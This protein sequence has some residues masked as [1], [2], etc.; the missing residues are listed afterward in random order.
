M[1]FQ[2][3]I[4]RWL[5]LV[6]KEPKTTTVHKTEQLIYIDVYTDMA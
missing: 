2:D 4:D 3:F 5:W 6:I 1:M